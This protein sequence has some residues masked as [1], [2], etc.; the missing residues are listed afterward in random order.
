MKASHTITFPSCTKRSEINNIMLCFFKVLVPKTDCLSNYRTGKQ[1]RITAT[2][3]PTCEELTILLLSLHQ[4][5]HRTLLPCPFRVL[6]V[7]MTN[8]PRPSTFSAT[9]CTAQ[10]R[11][12]KKKKHP[13]WKNPSLIHLSCPPLA[14]VRIFRHWSLNVYWTLKG[15]LLKS[16]SKNP[17]PQK[18][19]HK[20]TK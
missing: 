14:D 16:M 1:G 18:S 3:C 6:R 5:I 2:V 8:W 10:T 19:Q 11:R 20:L 9:W 4:S 12:R 15:N 17:S 13:L 7:F